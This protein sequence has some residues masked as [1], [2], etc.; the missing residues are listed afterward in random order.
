MSLFIIQLLIISVVGLMVQSA[1]VSVTDDHL[2]KRQAE[3]TTKKSTQQ[4]LEKRLFN[5]AGG[6]FNGAGGLIKDKVTLNVPEG[7]EEAS[8]IDTDLQYDNLARYC[9]HF[10]M[11]MSLKHHLQDL[12]L[13]TTITSGL[14]NDIIEKLSVML[15]KL[16]TVANTF[17]DLQVNEHNSSCT[18]FTPKDY[19]TIYQYIPHTDASLLQTIHQIAQ[20]WN[21][22]KSLYDYPGERHFN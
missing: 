6:V 22:D 10:I 13:D 17:D 11:A 12:L 7:Y 4:K 16:Q 20:F 1:P 8:G 5:A 21:Q 18:R 3:K 2:Q 14:S 15:T 9:M 19:K